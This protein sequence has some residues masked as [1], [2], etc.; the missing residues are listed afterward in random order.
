[1]R[2][3]SFV[4]ISIACAA[5]CS[6]PPPLNTETCPADGGPPASAGSAS[7]VSASAQGPCGAMPCSLFDT[8]EAAFDAVLATK[9]VVLAVGETHAPKDATVPSTTKRFTDAMLPK[10]Q[11]RATDLVLELWVANGKCGQ[12]EK[13]VQK[14]QKDVTATQADTNQ[15]EF[16]VLGTAA[17]KV[18]IE[19]H[20]LVPGCDEYARI[21]D[22]GA[23][24]VDAMLSMI[25]RLTARD[26]GALLAKRKE[27]DSMLVAYGG[28]MHNDA[29]PRKG[30]EAWSFG[31]QMNDATKGRYVEL[32]LIVPEYVKDTD[33][34][35]AQ[36][37]YPHWDREKHGKK[38]VLF[39][40]GPGAYALVFPRGAP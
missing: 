16:V 3:A 33:A 31:P 17:K 39:Q 18:G 10:L 5:A 6:K 19:P 1:M 14:Q 4:A 21:L 26:L 40:P 37:W 23:G 15:N 12:Q 9:P 20:V 34:W 7:S 27:G 32:D 30:R 8:P 38:A 28:A 11:G 24:D 2:L 22:A 36:P 25:A 13:Q 29:R 35:K